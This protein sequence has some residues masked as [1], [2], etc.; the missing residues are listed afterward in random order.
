M[1]RKLK[2]LIPFFILFTL[3]ALLYHEIFSADS[4]TIPSNLVGDPLPAFQ[5]P[6]LE[7]PQKIFSEKNLTGKVS[8]L[9]VWATWC[10][11]CE[12]EHAM[13]L[14]IAHDY[15]VPIYGIDYKDNADDAIKW[16]HNKG[17]PYVL[18]G[19]DAN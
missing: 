4:F 6:V 18:V 19:E 8:L 3:F 16:L 11:A 2:V 9:N 10:S 14:K 12:D 1:A 5:L 13:L 17:N 7:Q 15:R